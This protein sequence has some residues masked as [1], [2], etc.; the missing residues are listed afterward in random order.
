MKL[1]NRYNLP[2]AL[3][4]ACGEFRKPVPNR[5]GAGALV[6]SPFIRDL[7]VKHWDELEQDVSEML[8]MIQGKAVHWL[9]EQNVDI[10]EIA[11][12]KFQHPFDGW[13]ITGIPDLYKNKRIEDWKLTSVFSFLLGVKP[14]WEQILNVYAYVL[15]KH[16][17]EIKGLRINCLLRDWVISKTY[18]DEDYPKIPFHIIDL[19]L[20]TMEK[21]EM[22]I[23]ERLRLFSETPKPCMQHEM[24]ERGEKWAVKKKGGKRAINGGVYN[25]KEEAELWLEQADRS[26]YELEHRPGDRHKCKSYCPVRSVC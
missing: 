14:E 2:L 8:W 12:E 15:R 26:L 24:W 4:R 23:R 3:V 21:A 13:T 7:L 20:W 11:E 25:H 17:S 22:F 5:I 9:M 1:T 16:G 6:G 18:E 10:D 19:P